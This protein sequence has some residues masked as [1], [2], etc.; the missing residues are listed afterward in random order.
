MKYTLVI[1]FLFSNALYETFNWLCFASTIHFNFVNYIS[2]LM[3]F[4]QNLV[5]SFR[6]L[7]NEV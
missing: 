1:L 3:E 6:H 4:Q 5:N 2:I 7:E